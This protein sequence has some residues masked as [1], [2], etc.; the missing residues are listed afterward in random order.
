MSHSAMSDEERIADRYGGGGR[1]PQLAIIGAA[2]ALVVLAGIIIQVI[3]LGE[4]SV[5]VTN[6]GHTVIDDGHVRITFTLQGEE[7][8]TVGCSANAV[9][10]HFAEVGAKDFE[11]TLGADQVGRELILHTSERAAAGSVERCSVISAP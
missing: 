6:T 2:I 3:R 10:A 11:V 4:P 5:A 1:G 7:G 9:N 8:M